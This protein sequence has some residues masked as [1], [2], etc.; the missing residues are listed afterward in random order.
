MSEPLLI[1]VLLVGFAAWAVAD[2][3]RRSTADARR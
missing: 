3:V 2:V 1:L